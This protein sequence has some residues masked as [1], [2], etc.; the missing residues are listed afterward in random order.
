MRPNRLTGF[1]IVL[2]VGIPTANGQF[3][4]KKKDPPPA[5][6]PANVTVK[7]LIPS[8]APLAESAAS[9]EKGGLRITLEPTG[10]QTQETVVDSAREVAPPSKFGIV[11]KPDPNAIYVQHTQTPQLLVK[12]DRVIFHVHINNQLPRVFRG[13]GIAVQFNVAGKVTNV[14]PS[15]Y[16]DLVNVIIPPRSEQEIIIVG[17]KV[18]SIPSPC[19]IGV[20]LYD[21]VT[22]MDDAGNVTEKQNF[23]WYYSY[24]TQDSEKEIPGPSST[25][26]WVMP[27]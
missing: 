12:P 22:K 16:G 19:T 3:K 15:G 10:F 7:V 25:A 24:R 14:D 1:L 4:M 11:M 6:P 18:G 27:R 23:E 17:P 20:F 2:I 26:G 9:Q 8:L 13:A 21:V 5:P